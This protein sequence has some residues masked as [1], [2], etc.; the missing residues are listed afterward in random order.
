MAEVLILDPKD[1]VVNLTSGYTGSGDL[2]L[3]TG[4]TSGSATYSARYYAS[5]TP[6]AGTATASPPSSVA[7]VSG[8]PDTHEKYYW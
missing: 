4:E 3:Q 6:T 5:G 8:Y 2:T 1:A 7:C